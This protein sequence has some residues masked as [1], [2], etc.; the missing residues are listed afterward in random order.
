MS[1]TTQKVLTGVVV[2]A[3]LGAMGLAIY[4]ARNNADRIG[5]APLPSVS[6]GC[7]IGGCSGQICSGEKDAISTCEY[8]PE[9][10]CY[11][12]AVC[13]RQADGE[14]GWTETPDLTAC[15]GAD[16]DIILEK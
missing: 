12:G 1:P 14:C 10:S 3:V 7:Y 4:K 9:Y 6:G 15:L 2:A 5:S 8:K 13:E 11:Y 16:Y